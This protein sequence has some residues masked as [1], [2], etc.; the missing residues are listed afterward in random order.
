MFSQTIFSHRSTETVV[1]GFQHYLV[2]LGTSVLIPSFLVPQMGG[3]NEEK[4]RVIQTLLFVAGLNTLFQSY[5]GTRLPT[6][7]GGSYTFVL[8]TLSII[9]ANR[10][11]D[12]LDPRQRFLK[13][14]RRVQGALIAASSF[15]VVIGFSGIWRNVARYLSP[16]SAVPL[17]TLAGLGLYQ[18][19]FPNVAKCIE[20]GLPQIVLLVIFSQF[21]PHYLRERRVLFDRSAIIFSIAIVWLYAYFL[22]LGGAYKNRH[23]LTEVHCRSDQSGLI[24][25]AP[26]IMIPYPFQWGSPIF[27][28]GDAFSM[29]AASFAALIESTGTFIAASRFASATPVP[30]SILSRGVGWQG[31]GIFLNGIFGTLNGCTA[32]V[33]NVGLLALTRVGSR[34]VIQISAVFMIFFSTLGKIGAIFASIP[35]PIVAA[36]YCIFFGYV[37]SAG[38]GLLQFCNINSFRT[39]FI[40]GF[41][42][43]M[44]LSVPQYFDDFT[45]VAGHGPVHTGSRS[46]NDMLNVIFSSPATVAAIVAFFLDCTIRHRDGE[47][48]RDRGWHW[49]AKFRSFKTDPRSAEFYSLPFTLSK[50]FP[51]I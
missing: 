41:S 3:G 8:P 46:F 21:L 34:R 7:I 50:Y 29:M 23:P 35:L 5:F 26:W 10:Y 9:L 6:V 11:D 24:G 49:W 45:S 22:T 36:L 28:A 31:I 38:L 44:G 30:P 47:S 42:F 2:M 51:S 43:F 32:S 17:V 12:I 39:M 15:Q 33:E 25:A 14:M 48:D 40:L 19:G 27:H 1:L 20:I 13:T 16:L 18:L 4:A 37:A